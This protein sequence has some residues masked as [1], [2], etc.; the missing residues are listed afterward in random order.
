MRNEEKKH[1]IIETLDKIDKKELPLFIHTLKLQA[2]VSLAL[3]EMSKETGD[4]L[5][6]TCNEYLKNY[7]EKKR[8]DEQERE[9]QAK[10]YHKPTV[11]LSKLT[12][13]DI[14]GVSE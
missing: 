8:A 2:F 6:E 10:A 9:R 7:E 14:K 12:P 1:A 11:D 3:G 5:I 4:L 13:A